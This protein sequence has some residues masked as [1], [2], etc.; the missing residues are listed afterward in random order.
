MLKHLRLERFKNFEDSGLDLG[1][2]TLLVGTNASGKSNLR[3]AFR[4][5]HG[6]SRGYTMAEIIGEKWIEGG[7][8]QWK[9]IRGGTREVAYQQ[10]PAF[11]LEVTFDGP[12]PSQ[13]LLYR[14]EVAIGPNGTPPRVARERLLI[15]G[16]GFVFDSHPDSNPPPQADPLHLAVRLRKKSREGWVGPAVSFINERPVLSQLIEHPEVKLEKVKE[17]ARHTISALASMRFLDLSP[18]AMRLPSLPGQTILGDRGENLSSVLQ[19]ICEKPEL[20]HALTEWVR[21][22][23][24]LDA[25]EFEFT[26]D[27]TGRVLLTLVEENG[28]RTSVYSASDG[29]LRFLAMIAALLG[30]QP[31]RFYFFEELEN[32]IHPTR[33][34]LLIGLIEQKVATG[35]IQMVATSHSPQLLGTL[36]EASR[37]DAALIYRLPNQA[38]ARI[39]RIMGIPEAARVVQ[40]RDLARLHSSGWLEDAVAFTDGPEAAL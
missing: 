37:S 14:I 15:E 30:T 8:L 40:T 29:T 31:A 34:H 26:P 22:L 24:P 35:S 23:T 2:L 13:M 33:L 18:E 17:M 39:R 11:A 4:L 3:D 27:Q 36:S 16:K 10:A 12:E 5:L 38:C 21:E 9:G 28:Q 7:V 25:T 6:V 19:A 20:E 32:G 1:P